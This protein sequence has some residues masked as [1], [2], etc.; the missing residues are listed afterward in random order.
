MLSLEKC[1]Q[2]IQVLGCSQ[3]CRRFPCSELCVR[4]CTF[5]ILDTVFQDGHLF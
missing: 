2:G 5:E 1:K 3:C 4:L